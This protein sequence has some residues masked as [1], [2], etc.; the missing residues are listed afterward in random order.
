MQ[1]NC[2]Y[3]YIYV[4]IYIC[5]YIYNDCYLA[6][7]TDKRVRQT[8]GLASATPVTNVDFWYWSS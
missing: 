6:P 3:I 7:V 1:T 5:T 8:P 4:Y 2:I